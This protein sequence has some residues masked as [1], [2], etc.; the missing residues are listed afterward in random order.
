MSMHNSDAKHVTVIIIIYNTHINLVDHGL[1]MVLFD[2]LHG[3]TQFSNYMWY[4]DTN[5]QV[6]INFKF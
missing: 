4:V 1:H 2:V 6:S 3:L 5:V